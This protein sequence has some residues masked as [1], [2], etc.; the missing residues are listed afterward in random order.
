MSDTVRDNVWNWLTSTAMT[1]LQEGGG[2]IVMATRWHMDDPIGRLLEREPGKWKLI[3]FRAIAKEDEPPYRKE[4]EALC[5]ERYSLRTLLDIRD[6]GAM[7]SYQ[8]AALYQ[9]W[10]SPVR[11][12]IF[13]RD[14]WRFYRQAPSEL[15]DVIQSWD[16]AF[17]DKASSD[18]VVGQVW[19]RERRR[20]IPA[21]PGA[22]TLKL[23]L[24]GDGRSHA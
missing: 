24:N 13:K 2:V 15:N 23:R 9:Q 10:P 18:Y 5:T 16:C 6:G 8:W 7:S 17:K 3:N 14:D 21:R 1:R 11:G 12:G 22:G 4:G 19:G 20:Q